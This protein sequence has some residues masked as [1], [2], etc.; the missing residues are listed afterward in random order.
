MLFNVT[1]ALIEKGRTNGLRDKIGVL[2]LAGSFTE[3]EY[4]EL[5]TMLDN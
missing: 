4:N 1:K 5:I 2:Y 3:K